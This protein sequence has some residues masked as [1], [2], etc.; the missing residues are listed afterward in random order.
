MKALVFD[1]FGGPE[2]YRI[3]DMPVP[4]PGQG[5]VQV[6][7]FGAGLN[8][9]DWKIREGHFP[10]AA[11][12]AFPA[13]TLREFSG[14][15]SK[16][17]PGVTDFAVG[18]EVYGI[19]NVGAAAEYTVASTQAIG[20]RPPSMD[21]ADSAVVPLAGMTAWQA[22]FDHGD[23]QNGQRVL[24]TAASGGVGT[25]AVQLAKWKGA[26]VIGTASAKNHSI[27][28]EL[29]ADEVIDYTT[30]KVEQA[31]G[32]VDLVLHATSPADF[33][34][35]FAVL[36]T[37]GKIVSIVGPPPEEK[38]GKPVIPFMMQPSTANLNAL[39]GLIE[40]LKVRPVI[41][42]IVPLEKAVQAM[43]EL[44][45]GHTVGKMGIRIR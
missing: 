31:V 37:G 10:P 7:V 17:G 1:R 19:T 39:S 24:V 12:K 9:V 2:V 22:L 8:P 20:M 29:G 21:F 36:R 3:T 45:Q 6:E 26:Y 44:Q 34:A 4:E 41:D 16:L 25:Y 23:L 32:N 30:T 15:I 43:N 42:T 28:R 18:E 27:L 11:P 33:G 14:R 35:S 5:E 13:V 38:A 40:D